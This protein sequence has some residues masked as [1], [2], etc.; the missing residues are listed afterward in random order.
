MTGL[1]LLA[2]SIVADSG[3]EVIG[4]GPGAEPPREILQS[5][6][7]SVDPG[8]GSP[9]RVKGFL[10]LDNSGVPVLMPGT[11]FEEI[12]R[13]Q[14]LEAGVDAR[15][16]VF[17]F[18]S[19]EITGSASQTRAELRIVIRLTID[20]TAGRTVAIPLRM[21]NFFPLGPPDVSGLD[22]FRMTVSGNESGHLLMV[23]T[24]RR[25]EAVI[26]MN[27]AAR[28]DP[29][30]THALQFQLPD[31]PSLVRITTDDEQVTGEIVGRGDEVMQT[32][33]E[34]GRPA[35]FVIES[36]GGTFSLR[37][38]KRD[39]AT[40]GSPLLEIDNSRIVV[41][42]DSPQDQPIAACQ[43]II[44][45][46]RGSINTLQVR[47]P[48]NAV[49][50]DMPTLG[51]NAQSVELVSPTSPASSPSNGEGALLDIV[52]PEQERQ[53][54]IDLNFDIQFSASDPNAA[55]PLSFRAPEVI[56]ALRQRGE[57]QISTG[58]DYRLR[59]RSRPWVQSILGQPTDE[60]GRSYLFRYDRASFD[61]PIWLATTRR[62]LRLSTESEISLHD[63]IARIKYRIVSSGRAAEGTMLK[64]DMGSWRLRSIE[65]EDT[66]QQIESGLN[67]KH[68]EIYLESVA[69]G[70]PSPIRIVAE[71]DLPL[72]PKDGALT[73]GAAQEDIVFELPHITDIEDTMLVQASTV[74]V[75]NQGRLSFVVDLEGSQNIDRVINADTPAT[76]E[77]PRSHYR[78]IPPDAASKLIGRI[79]QQSPTISLA[80][81]ASIEVEGR[82]LRA[83]LDW[84]VNSSLDLE[85]R[86]PIQIPAQGPIASAAS[87]P[88]A[89]SARAT[90]ATEKSGAGDPST[91]E[92]LP[93]DSADAQTNSASLPSDWTVTVN[94]RPA[95]LESR[96]DDRY[97]LISDQLSSGSMAIRWK[98]LRPLNAPT[99]DNQI[100]TVSIPRPFAVD[101]TFRGTMR[102]LLQGDAATEILAA[103]AIGHYGNS[104]EG[105]PE[106]EET[107]PP[108]SSN[109]GL[110]KST[111]ILDALP[112]EPLRLRVRARQT[113]TENIF[114]SRAVLRT[115]V[116]YATRMEQLLASVE[117]SQELRLGLPPGDYSISTEAFVDGNFVTVRRE[118]NA[119]LI[120]LPDDGESHL[121]DLRV[122]LPLDASMMA[123]AI[124]P[125]LEL[126]IRVGRV[127]WEIAAPQ[128]SHV[129]WASPTLGR[130]MAWRF[131]RWRL[132]RESTQNSRSLASWVGGHDLIEVPRGNRY[133]YVGA[134]VKSFHAVVVSRT[135][136]WGVTGSIVLFIA[137]LL[138]FVPQ[139]RHPLFAVTAGVLFSGML[140]IAPDAAVLAGQLGMIALVLV[141]V[142]SAIRTMVQS[143]EHPSA[144]DSR[145]RSRRIDNSTQ[146]H[147]DSSGA[148]R[149][150][151]S[152]TRS[153][154]HASSVNKVTP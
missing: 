93:D 120:A 38:G 95:V 7:E 59:W 150:T 8:N 77:T 131:D 34:S 72:V 67:G 122:W 145:H 2:L 48:E 74:S 13:L 107:G 42:W 118:T 92:D 126:P 104:V 137:V 143:R 64:I 98:L 41:Q 151:L 31:V 146:M 109:R 128:D 111:M 144:L 33:R 3:T 89:A 112:R 29:G 139:T 136:L 49:L 50:L 103:D 62:Q 1:L 148:S 97:E 100:E 4:Q 58:D 52:I 90:N 51:P 108:P 26:T 44:R 70:D 30:P 76:V 117:G 81:D 147:K 75:A 132:Y 11:S 133:L 57:I 6:S 87:K 18:Q 5:G 53:Q 80:G 149:G 83:T 82:S 73:G 127:Y 114:V 99:S 153:L 106:A 15:S 21:R 115:A 129:I 154:A 12:E 9:L 61:L 140:V 28:V 102:V 45:S 78:V 119:L 88:A 121:V 69:N 125:A 16:Q 55:T 37:W 65:N 68:H 85:G 56:G 105:D 20:S 138:S 22:E 123:E 32:K 19:L 63:S 110:D 39:R 71:H 96:G 40:D 91:N 130:S 43:M 23:K 24:N 113:A 134:D 116:G 17:D 86:L 142:M 46:V 54:R 36:G 66:S 152:A 135:I 10:F 101:T 27:V 141:I 14:N 79:V 47:L 84:I 124:T 25:R 60:T 94:N 35:Q